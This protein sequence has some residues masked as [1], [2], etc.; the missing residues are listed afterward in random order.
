MP[1]LQYVFFP[2]G[3]TNCT[4]R[5]NDPSSATENNPLSITNVLRL[6]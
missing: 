6:K 4:L 3:Y 1:C 2:S 5:Y